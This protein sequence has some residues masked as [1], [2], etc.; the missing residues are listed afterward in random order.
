MIIAK[1]PMR[2]SLFG[3]GTDLPFYLE[4][5]G[6]GL[7]LS[8]A[9][10][11]YVYCSIHKRYDDE[12]WL[13]Y[14]EKEK[15]SA[16]SEIQNPFIKH[17]L[18]G[19]FGMVNG[20]EISYVS[21]I[22]G[23]GS[24]LGS[25]SAFVVATLVAKDAMIGRSLDES[26]LTSDATAVEQELIG[27]PIGGQDQAAS[28]RGGLLRLEFRDQPHWHNPMSTVMDEHN[29]EILDYL[30]LFE[31]PARTSESR[32]DEILQA[33]A[34]DDNGSRQILDGIH[35][36][37]KEV[38]EDL[39][40]A[41]CYRRIGNALDESWNLKRSLPGG[42]STKEIDNIYDKARLAGAW[43]G[44]VCGAGGGGYMVLMASK[45]NQEHIRNALGLRQIPFGIDRLG[46]RVVFNDE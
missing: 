36:I 29:H 42:V 14:S 16:I 10:D 28:V 31:L 25:S 40:P 3:G 12:I 27:K 33:A 32:G 22:P 30:M 45:P 8:M 13:N 2:I 43:G 20:F 15:V 6:T 7:I 26:R 24:G 1:A 41:K 39:L 9:I 19:T 18:Q 38:I 46:A 37:A 21:D 5:G 44:K 11:K 17:C 23:K 34:D 35:N 4:G